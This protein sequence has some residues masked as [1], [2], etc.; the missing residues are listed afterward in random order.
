MTGIKK[1][2]GENSELAE[3]GIVVTE[4]MIEAGAL[5]YERHKDSFD[6]FQLARM[7]YISMMGVHLGF[8]LS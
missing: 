8:Q 3:N 7:I 1:S 6:N 2:E 4:A 5:A